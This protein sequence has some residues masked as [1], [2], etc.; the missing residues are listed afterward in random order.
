MIGVLSEDGSVTSFGSH[1]RS[2]SRMGHRSTC[3]RNLPNARS[4]WHLSEKGQEIDIEAIR[5]RPGCQLKPCEKEA[6]DRVVSS[7]VRDDQIA[8]VLGLALR[9]MKKLCSNMLI[10]ADLQEKKLR[11]K[12]FIV[13]RVYTAKS[14][15]N[16][17]M[18]V[19][20]HRPDNYKAQA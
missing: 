1:Y 16:G 8:L 14:R 20:V 2:V 10:I 19:L 18:S 9:T 13:M 4:R 15:T 5:L 6:R 7:Q 3:S 11:I 12:S 17:D